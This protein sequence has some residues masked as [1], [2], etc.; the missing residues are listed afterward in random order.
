MVPMPAAALVEAVL[1]A[2]QPAVPLAARPAG[3]PTASAAAPV[4]SLPACA[5][6][7]LTLSFDGENGAFDGMQ[8]GGT[9]M[10]VRNVGAAPCRLTALPRLAFAGPDGRALPIRFDPPPGFHPGP[11]VPPV[12]VP[13]GA[14]VTAELRWVSGDVYPGGRCQ[15]AATVTAT[16]DG[17]A[18]GGPF[19]G[20]F[21]GPAA[22]A[23]FGQTWLKPDA[24]LR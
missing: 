15:D 10:V 3:R 4:A 7:D 17:Q 13:P 18:V 2:G 24:R 21:C 14:E 9:L 12:G 16:F 22:G 20:R 1:P 5:A 11:A 8:H 19:A 6:G 23:T